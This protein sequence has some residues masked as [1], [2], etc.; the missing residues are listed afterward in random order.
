M[1]FL[2]T[3]NLFDVVV[4]LFDH[5]CKIRAEGLEGLSENLVDLPWSPK[6]RDWIFWPDDVLLDYLIEFELPFFIKLLDS[7]FSSKLVRDG[8]IRV[9]RYEDIVKDPVAEILAL[10]AFASVTGVTREDV[11]G[12]LET[13]RKWPAT[14]TQFNKGVAGR[15]KQTLSSAHQEKIKKKVGY[16][17]NMDDL[18]T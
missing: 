7:W 11:T 13:A 2:Q 8:I 3:R 12:A 17:K 1:A 10:L 9:V 4:S 16:F 6:T 5:M 14:F 15:G 18:I